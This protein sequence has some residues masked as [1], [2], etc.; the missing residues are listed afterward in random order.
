[1]KC[2]TPTLQEI[3]SL[4]FENRIVGIYPFYDM[5]AFVLFEERSKYRIVIYKGLTPIRELETNVHMISVGTKFVCIQVQNTLVIFDGK[6]EIAHK[7]PINVVEVAVINDNLFLKTMSSLITGLNISIYMHSPRGWD[8]I[9][10]ARNTPMGYTNCY[11]EASKDK[12]TLI[13]FTNTDSI[14]DYYLHIL[15]IHPTEGVLVKSRSTINFYP[16]PTYEYKSDSNEN[17]IVFS[18]NDITLI[19][20]FSNTRMH[21]RVFIDPGLVLVRTRGLEKLI[22]IYDGRWCLS[23]NENSWRPGPFQVKGA[24]VRQDF[25][26]IWS[27]SS[28]HIFNFSDI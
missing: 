10:K 18:E 2:F 13:S 22:L 9:W 20:V 25:L 19:T 21:K 12:L 16:L 11:V 6:T 1:M 5:V 17:M 8:M 24:V 7:L 15:Q 27:Y 4:N 23:N 3:Y 26:A 14:Y 28:L